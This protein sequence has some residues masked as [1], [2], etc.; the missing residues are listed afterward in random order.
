MHST[1]S[2]T[3]TKKFALAL[4]K[5]PWLL[6]YMHFFLR[7]F[8]LIYAHNMEACTL[9]KLECHL[10]SP[11][12]L[13]LHTCFKVLRGESPCCFGGQSPCCFGGEAHVLLQHSPI[14][15]MPPCRSLV[16]ALTALVK[17]LREQSSTV[18][19]LVIPMIQYTTNLQNTVRHPPLVV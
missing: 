19:D 12:L 7:H 9:C 14:A 4:F 13:Q 10:F 5:T 16:M 11:T 17:A 3:T 1:I 18:H 15:G 6:W 2:H 8:Y